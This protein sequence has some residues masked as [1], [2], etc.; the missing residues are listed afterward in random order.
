MRYAIRDILHAAAQ[1]VEDGKRIISLNI[2]DPLQ[3]DFST[4]AHIIE[5]TYQAM[6]AGMNGYAPSSGLGEAIEAIRDD[7][8]R[9]G[10]ADV[11]GA[12]GQADASFAHIEGQ[13]PHKFHA[14][15]SRRRGKDG[16]S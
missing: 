3:F 1:A 16:L 7:A 6:L 15:D 5:A 10:G 12:G 11:V 14:L 13:E 4:P 2:G 8:S 9:Q